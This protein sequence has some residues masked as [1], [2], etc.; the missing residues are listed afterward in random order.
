MKGKILIAAVLII[1]GGL[2]WVGDKMNDRAH[3]FTDIE[4]MI[5]VCKE[6]S[7]LMC[8]NKNKQECENAINLSISY[9]DKKHN[10]DIDWNNLKESW[11]VFTECTN[12]SLV[13]YFDDD[14]KNLYTCLSKTNYSQRLK[15]TMKELTEK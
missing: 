8:T 12:N 4:P 1:F 9:C 10:S 14:S 2:V 13:A 15:K 5:N 7:F 11:K 3:T 6:T